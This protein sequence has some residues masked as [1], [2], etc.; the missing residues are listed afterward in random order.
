MSPEELRDLVIAGLPGAPVVVALG[1]GADSAVAAWVCAGHAPVR[2][3]FVHH[4]LEG[5]DALRAAAI[6]VANRVSL[7]LEVLSSP[8]AEGGNLEARA[9][10]A[11]WQA[12]RASLNPG[13]IVVT[14]HSQDDL[15]ETVLIN[16]L[17]GAGSRG[18]GAMSVLRDDV[19]RPLA[20]VSRSDLRDMAETLTLPFVDDPA[21]DDP[22]HLRNRVRAELIPLL[23]DQYRPGARTTLARAG[24]LLAA[25]DAALQEAARQVPFREDGTAL[26]APTAVLTT[27]PPPVAARAIRRALRILHPPYAGTAADVDAVIAI[28][29]G[30]VPAA[31]LSSGV[32]AAREGPYVA[33]WS[34]E[35]V[36]PSPSTLTVPGSVRFGTVLVTA[37][38]VT[39][40]EQMPRSTALVDPAI[41]EAGVT[42]RALEQGERIDILDGTKLVR[43][44]LAEARVPRRKRS[45]W[46][47]LANGAKIAAIVGGRVAPWARPA[48][49]DAVAVTQERT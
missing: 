27:I 1:G 40:G 12:I 45:A 7:S 48:G 17:R 26:L 6:E 3:V 30:S 21:N 28:A 5:S 10:D 42:L 41:F 37:R 19:I 4:D 39:A 33:L 24:S 32:S 35:P 25:D 2:A 49:V 15:A 29:A 23:E 14:G 46:P 36:V 20:G 16:L 22:R 8:V 18:L 13:E 38:G 34:D 9:R 44:A 43:D 47:V 11:R 31:T